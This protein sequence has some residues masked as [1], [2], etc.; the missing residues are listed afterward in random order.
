MVLLPTW[1]RTKRV[2]ARKKEWHQD[3]VVVVGGNNKRGTGR[4]TGTGRDVLEL[5]E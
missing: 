3:C 5:A 4:A 1:S 2:L